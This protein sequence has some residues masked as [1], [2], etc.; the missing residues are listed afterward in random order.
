MPP[1]QKMWISIT[2]PAGRCV[3]LP[4]RSTLGGCSHLIGLIVLYRC[5][6]FT[7]VVAD[8][9]RDREM[10]DFRISSERHRCGNGEW[11][12]RLSFSLSVCCAVYV[13]DSW[14]VTAQAAR[15]GLEVVLKSEANSS[16][17][18]A[19]VHRQKYNL[20][21]LAG[22]SY[23]WP[24]KEATKGKIFQAQYHSSSL[25]EEYS[26]GGSKFSLGVWDYRK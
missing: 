9:I 21:C 11:S 24:P 16:V 12:P 4:R 14:Q 1:P 23:A 5:A 20:S 26:F 7:A 18:R 17:P 6:Y 8:L 3:A 15:P 25:E 22:S 2:S 19:R 10:I 13:F